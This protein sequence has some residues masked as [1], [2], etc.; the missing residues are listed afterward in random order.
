MEK[1]FNL[2][3]KRSHFPDSLDIDSLEKA[4]S[5]GPHSNPDHRCI[6]EKAMDEQY[7]DSKASELGGGMN[8]QEGHQRIY[9][10]PS[11]LEMAEGSWGLVKDFAKLLET[12][13]KKE[14]ILTYKTWN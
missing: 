1:E 13:P 6:I 5:R 7:P 4:Y 11:E 8:V 12:D 2:T 14:L 3:L 9:Y 10:R